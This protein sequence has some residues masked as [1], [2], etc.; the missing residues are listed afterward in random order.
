MPGAHRKGRRTQGRQGSVEK[1]RHQPFGSKTNRSGMP[2]TSRALRGT[3]DA[4]RMTKS[5][6]LRYAATSALTTVESMNVVAVR[7]RTT[8]RRSAV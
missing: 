5:I 7:S 4:P 8:V 2:S 1:S 6:P 3:P